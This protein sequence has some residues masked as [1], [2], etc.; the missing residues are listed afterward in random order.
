[1][2]L[3]TPSNSVKY[4][5]F[6]NILLEKI[7][8]KPNVDQLNE[9][10]QY[11]LVQVNKSGSEEILK[12]SSYE[13]VNWKNNPR[14]HDRGRVR[15]GDLLL[16]Y[17]GSHSSTYKKQLRKIYRV[18]STSDQNKHFKLAE[19]R[20]LNGLSLEEIK[21][22]I[23]TGMLRD[24][25]FGKL[26]QQGFNILKI[27][28]SDYDSVFSFDSKKTTVNNL[29]EP[30]LWLVRAGN[31]GQGE[32]VALENNLVG[33]GYDGLP[34]L[35]SISEFKA[36]KEHYIKTH[37]N[38]K[39]GNVGQVVPQIWNFMY[40]IRKGDLVILPLKTQN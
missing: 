12:N 15:E 21:N 14:D 11:F 7:S 3:D 24:E 17:F 37:P 5:E 8:E 4:S 6:R 32:Q 33:I 10:I 31:V 20:D 13:H 39:P 40:D 9:R 1:M 34:G 18:E 19:E 26:S 35:D 38:A 25:V 2:P 27:E 16:V 29:S 36:F 22:A 23:S 28:K 30:G